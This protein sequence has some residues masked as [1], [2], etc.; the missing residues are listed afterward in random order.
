[1]YTLAPFK[2]AFRKFW[3]WVERVFVLG[4]GLVMGGRDYTYKYLHLVND[5][6]G[7]CKCFSLLNDAN[8]S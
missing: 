4:Q 2:L 3:I 7:G 6:I 8:G 5:A 1:M